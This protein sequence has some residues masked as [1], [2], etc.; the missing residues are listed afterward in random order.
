MYLT[1]SNVVH[2]LLGREL[3]TSD[4]VVDG[5]FVVAEAGRRNRNYKVIRRENPGLFIKQIAASQT[6]AV[7][8][9]QREAMCYELARSAPSFATLAALTPALVD[10]DAGRHVL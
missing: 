2:Y 6:Q 3:I 5:D 9:L 8:T 4:S 7:M 10:Y 1:A